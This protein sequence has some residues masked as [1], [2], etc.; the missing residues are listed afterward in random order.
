MYY[1]IRTVEVVIRDTLFV[2]NNLKHNHVSIRSLK[3][4]VFF[5]KRPIILRYIVIERF[6]DTVWTTNYVTPQIYTLHCMQIKVLA[7]IR[8]LLPHVSNLNFLI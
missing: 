5:M 3:K 1:I 8:R 4:V 7:V 2:I 6:S